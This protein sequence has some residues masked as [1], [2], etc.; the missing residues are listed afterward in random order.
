MNNADIL[1]LAIKKKKTWCTK[2]STQYIR[3]EIN[4]K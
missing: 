2:F 4:N 3:N 1:D